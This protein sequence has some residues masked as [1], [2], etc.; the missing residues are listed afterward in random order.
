[1][2]GRVIA[3]TKNPMKSVSINNIIIARTS[4]AHSKYSI[5]KN[6]RQEGSALLNEKKKNVGKNTAAMSWL[7]TERAKPLRQKKTFITLFI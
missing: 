4:A 7:T 3:K 2:A 6:N 1:L 5:E